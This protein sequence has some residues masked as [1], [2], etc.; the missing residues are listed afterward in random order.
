MF[1]ENQDFGVFL[2]KTQR[3]RGAENFLFTNTEDTKG[4]RKPLQSAV[5]FNSE[6]HF[7]Q[8]WLNNRQRLGMRHYVG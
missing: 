4:T 5:V 2:I 6:A 1:L 8:P 7:L 3:H